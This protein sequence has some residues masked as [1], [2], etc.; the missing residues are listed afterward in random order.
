VVTTVDFR[1][2]V[3]TLGRLVGEVRDDHLDGP[4]PP[5]TRPAGGPTSRDPSCSPAR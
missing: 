2:V 3:R 5:R 4:T 1:P